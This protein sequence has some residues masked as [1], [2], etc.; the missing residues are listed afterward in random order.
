MNLYNYQ[1]RGFRMRRKNYKWLNES[2]YHKSINNDSTILKSTLEISKD[3][4]LIIEETRKQI[5][6]DI[7]KLNNIQLLD[8]NN[9]SK[10]NKEIK[11]TLEKIITARERIKEQQ[12]GRKQCEYDYDFVD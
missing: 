6:K 8:L 2:L 9:F 3:T 11:I 1:Q 12:Q 10:E 7:E 4:K 5:Y